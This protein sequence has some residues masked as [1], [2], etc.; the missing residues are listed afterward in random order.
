MNKTLMIVLAASLAVNVFLAGHVSGKLISGNHAAS[1]HR[2]PPR[3]GRGGPEGLS[4][5]RNLDVLT[6][7]VRE[8]FRRSVREGLP[9]MRRNFEQTSRAHQELAQAL[10][11][12][13]WD[14]ALAEEKLMAVHEVQNRQRTMF[15]GSFFDALET[16]SLEDRIAL[17]DASQN[18][19]QGRRERR[20][21]GGRRGDGPP[22]PPEE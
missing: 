5:M 21:P 4:F 17:V 16:L 15:T 1:E 22:P 20:R 3:G 19:R 7:E 8:E 18:R 12:D 2:P 10:K 14:R 9:A 13:P 11:S 6:P